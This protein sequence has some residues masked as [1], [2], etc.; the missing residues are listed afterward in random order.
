MVYENEILECLFK[1]LIYVR[2]DMNNRDHI[3]SKNKV[4][5]K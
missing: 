5:F 1:N 2:L 3:F 4:K